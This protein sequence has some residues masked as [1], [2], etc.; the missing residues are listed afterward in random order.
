MQAASPP[1]SMFLP[2]VS[3]STPMPKL[4][5][6]FAPT[7]DALLTFLLCDTCHQRRQLA[8]LENPPAAD[9]VG[10]PFADGV[11]QFDQFV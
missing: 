2:R 6:A 11:G 1:A 10:L 8:Q 5:L 3:T 4:L 7:A 9:D